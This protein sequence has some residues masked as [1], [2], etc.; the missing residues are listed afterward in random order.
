MPDDTTLNNAGEV[1]R[2]LAS[3]LTEKTIAVIEGFPANSPQQQPAIARLI[4]DSLYDWIE[5]AER[6]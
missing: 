1:G 5:E 3:D 6:S 4:A 2:S